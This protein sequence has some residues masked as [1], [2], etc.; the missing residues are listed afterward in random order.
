[1]YSVKEIFYSLQGEGAMTGK[2]SIFCRFSGCNLWNGLENSRLKATCKFCDTNFVGINGNNGGKYTADQ[3]AQ[4]IKNLW[5]KNVHSSSTQPV[6]VVLTG[7]EPL[8]QLDENL[9]TILKEYNFTLALET[10]GTQYSENINK[11]LSM[12]DWICV[13]PKYGSTLQIKKGDELKV[14]FPQNFILQDY[15]DFQNLDFKHFYI[16][17]MATSDKIT[18]TLNIKKAIEFC[19]SYPN[20]NLS[21]QTH[22]YLNLP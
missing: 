8:L 9:I 13:S 5:K 4:C 1:M 15:K 14:V 3:L 22:K 7:G 2:P 11:V 12:L 19:Q 20:W 10:N 18:H 16:Q 6:Y 21:I 17:P